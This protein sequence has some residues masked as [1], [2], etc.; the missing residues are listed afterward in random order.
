MSVKVDAP[1]INFHSNSWPLNVDFARV[2][3]TFVWNFFHCSS[4]MKCVRVAGNKQLLKISAP[5]ICVGNRILSNLI[6]YTQ[7]G[8]LESLSNSLPASEFYME[9]RRTHRLQICR[10]ILYA[11]QFLFLFQINYCCSCC[12]NKRT[13]FGDERTK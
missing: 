5:K 11:L 1:G 2:C 9:K 10:D 12:Q 8:Y 7:M 4:S 13:N 6:F 3:Y